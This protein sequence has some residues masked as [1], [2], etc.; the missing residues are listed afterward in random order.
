MVLGVGAFTLQLCNP[1]KCLRPVP[2]LQTLE[3]VLYR[4]PT[5][6][7]LVVI[8]VPRTHTEAYVKND[9]F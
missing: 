5:P 6:S 1:C 4:T 8:N 2:Y 3:E 9:V 7:A